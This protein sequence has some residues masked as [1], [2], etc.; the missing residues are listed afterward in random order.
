MLRQVKH[1]SVL[2]AVLSVEQVSGV[3]AQVPVQ[4]L[5]VLAGIS[6]QIASTC[7]VELRS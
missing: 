7:A 5:H 1:C 6:N 2:V 3:S 4:N